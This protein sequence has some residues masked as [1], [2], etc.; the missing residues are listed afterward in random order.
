MVVRWAIWISFLTFCGIEGGLMEVFYGAI[1]FGLL[2]SLWYTVVDT[3][4][5]PVRL[6]KS[7]PQNYNQEV[8]TEVRK[9]KRIDPTRPTTD[10]FAG[11]IEYR[12]GGNG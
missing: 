4:H 1:V 5:R 10:D 3:W 2:A 11:M 9:G 8:E 7:E 6:V 12:K